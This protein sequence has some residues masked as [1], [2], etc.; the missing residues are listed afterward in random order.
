MDLRGLDSQWRGFSDIDIKKAKSSASGEEKKPKAPEKSPPPSGH[1]LRS[2][3]PLEKANTV[4][5][6]STVHDDHAPKAKAIPAD[7]IDDNNSSNNS[8]EPTDEAT[9]LE[10]EE[11]P[12]KLNNVL[13]QQQ[14]VPAQQTVKGPAEADLKERYTYYN[15]LVPVMATSISKILS[16]N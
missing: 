12:P 5:S 10:H 4:R 11:T 2:P 13:T 3:H 7:Q 9:P 16:F 8:S 14:E 15:I 1:A 6:S